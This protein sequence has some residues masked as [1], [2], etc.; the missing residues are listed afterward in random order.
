MVTDF[1]IMAGQ[2]RQFRVEDIPAIHALLGIEALPAWVSD[3]K[4]ELIKIIGGTE[5]I[6]PDPVVRAYVLQATFKP[7]EVFQM[8]LSPLDIALLLD[9]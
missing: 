1:H 2:H 3:G 6:P 5:S 9:G 4:I 8:D 7:G